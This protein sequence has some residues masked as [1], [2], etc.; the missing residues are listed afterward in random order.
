MWRTTL[1]M[2]FQGQ[3]A[4]APLSVGFGV[5]FFHEMDCRRCFFRY[6]WF[7]APACS[8]LEC[9][10]APPVL[11][12]SHKLSAGF[13]ADGGG[14]G[15]LA[16][17]SHNRSM[18]RFEPSARF[19]QGQR[20]VRQTN[21]DIIGEVLAEPEWDCG[22]WW[23]R[24]RFGRRTENVAEFDLLPEPGEGEQ[25]ED[26]ALAGRWGT[27]ETLRRAVAVERILRQ[28][29]STVYSYNAQR[30]QFLPHQYKPLLKFL[31]SDDRRLLV[32]DEVGLGKTIEAGL[33]LAERRSLSSSG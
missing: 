8:V 5:G 4:R 30:I 20:V 10:P 26:L 27:F 17:A 16:T 2:V 11:A 3:G 31:E 24:V 28:N 14:S 12:L 15:G 19:S 13:A 25:V 33:V 23:Y 9:L 7:P 29:R 32:A 6:W 18:S 22:D 21:P 1:G